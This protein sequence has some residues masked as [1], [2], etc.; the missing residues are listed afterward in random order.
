[1][2]CG[3]LVVVHSLPPFGSPGPAR[4]DQ[5]LLPIPAKPNQAGHYCQCWNRNEPIQGEYAIGTRVEQSTPVAQFLGAP[6]FS[7]PLTVDI[8]AINPGTNVR[9]INPERKNRLYR[10]D[11]L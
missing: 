7:A 11:I 5:L 10:K 6:N 4:A 3:R 9:G 1:M 2:N 8:A